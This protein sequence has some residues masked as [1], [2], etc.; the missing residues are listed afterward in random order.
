MSTGNR[1]EPIAELGAG[2]RDTRRACVSQMEAVGWYKQ[3]FVA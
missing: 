1:H 3:R 2:T